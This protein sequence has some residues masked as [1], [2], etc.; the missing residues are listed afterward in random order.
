MLWFS[1][2]VGWSS[3]DP[4]AY[5]FSVADSRAV[6]DLSDR[7]GYRFSILDVGGGFPGK[8]TPRIPFETVSTVLYLLLWNVVN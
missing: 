3:L 8:N 1:F 4:K 2:H 6:F 5:R 7:Y